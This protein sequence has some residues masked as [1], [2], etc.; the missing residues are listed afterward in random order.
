MNLRVLYLRRRGDSLSKVLK[1]LKRGGIEKGEEILA[2]AAN[3]FNILNAVRGRLEAAGFKDLPH[4]WTF[5]A[6]FL[7]FRQEEGG[8]KKEKEFADAL[9]GAVFFTESEPIKVVQ[10]EENLQVPRIIFGMVLRQ[11]TLNLLT[12][13]SVYINFPAEPLEALYKTYCS[14]KVQTPPSAVCKSLAEK[15]ILEHLFTS[16]RELDFPFEGN[17]SQT[18]KKT[19]DFI[20]Q[21]WEVAA[22]GNNSI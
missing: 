2:D 11:L 21:N 14:L 13:S 18:W 12:L 3:N 6:V 15:G 4:F 7:V 1:E 10:L 16:V 8:E 22:D 19:V 5:G 9:H 20:K 17:L